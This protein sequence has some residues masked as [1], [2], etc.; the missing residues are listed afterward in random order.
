MQGKRAKA[1][2]NSI[3][4]CAAF[5]LSIMSVTEA[6]ATTV[7]GEELDLLEEDDEFE[8]FKAESKHHVHT[9]TCERY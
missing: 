9:P 7:V 8:E 6:A 2:R 4:N 3:I 5:A 1:I